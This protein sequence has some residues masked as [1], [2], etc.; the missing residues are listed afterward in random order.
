MSEHRI[1]FRGGWELIPTEGDARAIRR[2]TLPVDWPPGIEGPIQLSRRFGRPPMDR[3]LESARLELRG[4]PGLR[5]LRLNGLDLEP[6]PV[7]VRDWTVPLA[8]W[9][10]ARNILTLEVNPVLLSPQ[11]TPGGWGWIALV[12]ATKAGPGE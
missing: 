7:G 9:L 1:R 12:I 5:S 8:E 2:L 4:V 11:E 6:P 3:A 10:D